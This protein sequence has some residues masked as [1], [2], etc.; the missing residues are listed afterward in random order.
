MQVKEFIN[1]PNKAVTLLGMSGAGKSHISAF[2]GGWGWN[3]YSCDYEIGAK[4]LK[5]KL[6]VSVDNISALSDYLGRIGEFPLD[7]FIARQKSYYDAEIA[8]LGA[9][10][11]TDGCFIH[12]STGSL[13]EIEDKNL[14]QK[15]GEQTLFVYLKTSAAEERELLQRAYDYP[16]PLFFPP[17]FLAQNLKIYLSEFNINNLDDIVSDEFSHWIFPKLF[18]A[19]KP[20]YQ[21]LADKYGVTIPSSE[22]R[23]LKSADEFVEIIAKYL[24]R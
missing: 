1:N 12:D 15:I 17:E 18:E 4:Y 23:N 9:M 10:E 7:K 24:E 8:A 14:M 19:R 22:F 2:M 11:V 20:K 21:S 3:I 5:D 16:K 6:F 13:C